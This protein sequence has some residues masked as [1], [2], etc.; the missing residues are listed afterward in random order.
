MKYNDLNSN[1][2][3]HDEK[4]NNLHGRP[5][6]ANIVKDYGILDVD[7]TFYTADSNLEGV[8]ILNCRKNLG[9][10]TISSQDTTNIFVNNLIIEGN[11]NILPLSK[12]VGTFIGKEI[13]FQNLRNI[14]Y[15][16]PKLHVNLVD[17]IFNIPSSQLIYRTFKEIDLQ[18]SSGAVYNKQYVLDNIENIRAEL[19]S[20]RVLMKKNYLYSMIGVTEVVNDNLKIGTISF[21]NSEDVKFDVLVVKELCFSDSDMKCNVFFD[22]AFINVNE[23]LGESDNGFITLNNN[24]G[25]VS[26]NNLS[27]LN[28]NFVDIYNKCQNSIK[29]NLS[30][31]SIELFDVRDNLLAH[32]N[33]DQTIRDNM[34]L[35]V[36]SRTGNIL[37]LVNRPTYLSDLVNDTMFISR[38][39]NLSDLCNV[40]FARDNLEISSMALK[41]SDLG[42]SEG[43]YGLTY[44]GNSNM[45]WTVDK[46]ILET[47]NLLLATPYLNIIDESFS[48][49]L[50]LIKDNSSRAYNYKVLE[51][52]DDEYFTS[53]KHI[54]NENELVRVRMD[55][56]SS[57]ITSLRNSTFVPNSVTVY[58]EMLKI[59]KQILIKF[60]IPFEFY[61]GGVDKLFH[62][63]S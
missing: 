44:F 17:D 9:I 4:L 53:R 18:T 40:S 26:Y 19:E 3:I 54:R 55:P 60:E 13:G 42:G 49:F 52:C 41:D 48:D 16:F 37:D 6:F 10:G 14:E 59:A 58:R 34:G 2:C 15:V 24:N 8:L 21:Q 29:S 56:T 32:N 22:N 57:E 46:I 35:K 7:S 27:N 36:F 25:G 31:F 12:H 39:E 23:F 11:I 20:D 1:S 50:Y 33:Q 63:E 62:Y 47:S 38:F 51:K 61:E 28:N 5:S 43:F 30:E 45:D